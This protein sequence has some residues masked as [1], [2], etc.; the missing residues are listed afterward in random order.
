MQ[1]KYGLLLDFDGVVVDSE[2]LYE[3]AMNVQF[4][5][6]GIPVQPEDW[7]FFKGKD[8][9]S[10]FPYIRDKYDKDIDTEKMQGA[11]RRD[12]LKEFREHMRYIPG[13]TEFFRE[14]RETFRDA[15][16]TSTSREIM[17]WTF[18]NVPVDNIFSHMITSSEVRN[19][20]PDPEP[21]RKAAELIG[22]PPQRC[23]V[24][25]DSVNGI[26]SGIAAG[27]KVVGMTTTFAPEVLQEAHLI[28]DSYRALS[29]QGLL[30]LLRDP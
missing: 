14:A 19:T 27:A 1:K 10:V 3:K 11:Y 16:V 2:P 17:E 21:Y 6:Y 30:E 18:G 13:F 26:R 9:K 15:L 24:I 5:K 20:K 12:L 22:L 8:A 4:R 28:V 25:E 23:V 29:V 7:L